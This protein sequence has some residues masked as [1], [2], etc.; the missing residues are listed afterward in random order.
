ML[1]LVC[2]SLTLYG[3]GCVFIV[4]IAQ[5]L[6]SVVGQW[7]DLGIGLCLWMVIVAIF[8][9]PLTWMGTPKDFW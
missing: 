6:S 9:T 2:I 7:V 4:L 5:L 3:A 8:L 1:S